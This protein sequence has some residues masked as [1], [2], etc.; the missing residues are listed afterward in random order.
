MVREL[1]AFGS[2]ATLLV[3]AAPNLV[4]SSVSVA[5]QGATLRVTDAARNTG[6]KPAARSVTGFYLGGVR[7]GQ[8]RVASLPAAGVSR[9]ISTLKIPVT[10]AIGTYHLRACA[11]DRRAVG[12]KSERDN[13]RL[14]TQTVRVTDRTPPTFAGLEAATTCLPGPIGNGRSSSFHLRWSAAAD[15]ATPQAEIV[16]DVY[17][18]TSPGAENFATPTYTTDAGATT[19]STPRLSSTETYYFVVRA[20]DRAG[21]RDANRAEQQ[22]MNMCL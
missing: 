3:G 11:D 15:K 1:A 18:A 12:E 4:V 9:G 5:Q 17:Q 2:L 7:I 20:R 6:S 10:V 19:F 22:G 13:C 16:Y 14:S 21:N 8:R